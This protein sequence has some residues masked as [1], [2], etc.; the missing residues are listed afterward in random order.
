MNAKPVPRAWLGGYPVDQFF[1][2]EIAG[3]SLK[4]RGIIDGSELLCR[5]L[6]GE[7]PENND[8]VVARVGNEYTVKVLSLE[9]DR[10]LLCDGDGKMIVDV[11]THGDVDLVAQV[12]MITNWFERPN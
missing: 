1:W 11:G 2:I 9:N 4:D 6:N 10:A 3:E 8:V 12:T 5:R 7:M